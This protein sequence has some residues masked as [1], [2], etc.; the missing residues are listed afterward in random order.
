MLKDITLGQFYPADSLIHRLD[1]RVKLLATVIYIVCCFL[2]KGVIGLIL[3]VAVL[4]VAIALSK[5]PPKKMLRGVKALWP[6]LAITAFFNL[7]FSKGELLWSLGI[8]TITDSGLH[9]A[10]FYSIRLVLLV[11]GTSVMTLTTSP[12]KL[13]DG[14]EEGLKIFS[15]MGAPIHE[16]AMMMSI[17]LRFIP[18][19]G[20]EAEKIKKA[21]LARGAG[22]DEGGLV[23]KA[24]GLIPILVP[25]FVSAFQRANDLSMAMEARCY[26]GGKGRTK[27]HPLKYAGRDFGAYA[28]TFATLAAFIVLFLWDLPLPV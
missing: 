9:N 23:Q 12:S 4:V 10:I 14:M 16:I 17:A 21:Q 1:P 2:F 19:L 11:I 26:H 15:K 18:I 22:F 6:L 24:K 7:F 5:V 27:L 20:D 13:T 8:L 3:V 25:L 28:C